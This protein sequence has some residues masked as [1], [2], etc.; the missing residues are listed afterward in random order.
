[1][2][3]EPRLHIE[4]PIFQAARELIRQTEALIDGALD[5]PIRLT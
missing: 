3:A 5:Q 2:S 4:R 1:M